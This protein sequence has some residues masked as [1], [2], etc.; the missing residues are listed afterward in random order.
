[1]ITRPELVL[2]AKELGVYEREFSSKELEE[3][4][5]EYIRTNIKKKQTAADN[6]SDVLKEYLYNYCQCVF[7]DR[8]GN[9]YDPKGNK[10]GKRK[11]YENER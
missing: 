3:K 1:M 2:I 6:M 8:Y 9:L 4:I 5:L 10:I 11:G 7:M